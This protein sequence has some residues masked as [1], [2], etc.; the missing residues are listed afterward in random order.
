MLKQF[1][2]TFLG[3]SDNIKKTYT[4]NKNKVTVESQ[5][6]KPSFFKPPENVI[7]SSHSNMMEIHCTLSYLEITTMANLHFCFHSWKLIKCNIV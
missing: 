4:H 1:Q 7:S 3:T 2:W 6:L 5:F